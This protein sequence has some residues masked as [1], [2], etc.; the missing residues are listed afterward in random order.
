MGRAW[1]ERPFHTSPHTR[2]W[3]TQREIPTA[4]CVAWAAHSRVEDQVLVDLVAAAQAVCDANMW[5]SDGGRQEL[6]GR[7][8]RGPSLVWQEPPVDGLIQ[9]LNP[10]SLITRL[11]RCTAC[12]VQSD[13]PWTAAQAV[14][15][16]PGPRQVEAKVATQRGGRGLGLENEI[17]K[18]HEDHPRGRD[19]RVCR[20]RAVA[21]HQPR[22]RR[23][24]WRHFAST[25]RETVNDASLCAERPGRSRSSASPR[26]PTRA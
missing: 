12:T 21:L 5:R 16:E 25:N 1:G 9:A 4:A 8:E 10:A 7:P 19:L 26:C 6:R 11:T 13:A 14:E 2:G 20:R 3:R 15:V 18:K 22:D 23:S 17:R 24:K